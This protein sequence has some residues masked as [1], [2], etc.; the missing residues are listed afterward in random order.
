MVTGRDVVGV[1]GTV[2]AVGGTVAEVEVTGRPGEGFV[3]VVVVVVVLADVVEG[4][5]AAPFV[6]PR[7][8]EAPPG[9]SPATTTPIQVVAAPAPATATPV[10][11][12]MRACAR[13]RASAA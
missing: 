11:N 3:V 7:A 5:P 10:R 2:V 6:A 13:R 8:G 9:C 4:T 1:G 12:R